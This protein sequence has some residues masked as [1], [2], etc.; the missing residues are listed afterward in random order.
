MQCSIL[1]D[2]PSLQRNLSISSLGLLLFVVLQHSL[3]VILCYFYIVVVITYIVFLT[4]L[5]SAS[6][7]IVY[8]IVFSILHIIIIFHLFM[9][10]SLYSYSPIKEQLFCFQFCYQ[11]NCCYKYFFV[12]GYIFCKSVTFQGYVANS[13]ISGS[14]DIDVLIP[15]FA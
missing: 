14:K 9:Y 4:L 7:S 12:Y 6:L 1:T 8:R 3:S 10:H 13:R 15:L 2:L 11:K 5:Q